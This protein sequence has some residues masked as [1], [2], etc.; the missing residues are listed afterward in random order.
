MFPDVELL[1]CISGFI[2]ALLVVNL[3]VKGFQYD[4]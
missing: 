3:F 2:S 1:S 4:G